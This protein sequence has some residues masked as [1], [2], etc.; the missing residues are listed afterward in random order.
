MY[1][2]SRTGYSK[3]N[4]SR[5]VGR[6]HKKPGEAHD[7]SAPRGHSAPIGLGLVNNRR[8]GLKKVDELTTQQLQELGLDGAAGTSTLSRFAGHPFVYVTPYGQDVPEQELRSNRCE[9]RLRRVQR[10]GLEA[11]TPPSERPVKATPKPFGVVHDEKQW[12]QVMLRR[13]HAEDRL[14]VPLDKPPE[15]H[16]NGFL[17]DFTGTSFEWYDGYDP[18]CG[19]W[20]C[21]IE[22]GSYFPS[23]IV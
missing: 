4:K 3:A 5:L 1:S 8:A 2:S 20:S 16:R 9:G 6:R 19:L 7:P 23:E 18:S 21:G 10:E 17:G 22:Q 13:L 12:F 14:T 11:T 15:H